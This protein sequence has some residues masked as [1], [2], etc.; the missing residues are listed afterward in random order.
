[1]AHPGRKPKRGKAVKTACNI[2]FSVYP[3]LKAGAR[4]KESGFVVPN[5]VRKLKNFLAASA[6]VLLLVPG[7][8][9]ARKFYPDDPLAKAPPPRPVASA[10]SR[11][12]SEY[13]DFF[14][15]TFAQPGERH[16]PARRI[17]AQ[18]VNTLGEVPDSGWYTNRHYRNS[19]S[20]AEL[21]RGAG[22][23]NAPSS[24]GPW[25]VVAAKAEG[26]TPGFTVV[27]P[28]GRRYVLKFDP[29]TN[30]EMATAADV[31]SS[32]F[33]HALGYFVPDNYIVEFAREQL[34]LGEAVQLRDALGRARPMTERDLAEVLLNVPRSRNGQYRAVASFYLSGRPLGPFRYYGTRR[35]DP[36]DV[37]PHEHRRDLRGLSI[38]CA[39]LGH[40]DS[41]SIN[42]LDI[43]V[44]ES[45][46]S[47]LQHFL[48]DFGSTLGSASNGP[49]S[50]RSGHEYLFS[51][52]P[53]MVQFFTFGLL[54]PSWARAKYPDLPSVGRFEG[55]RF[56]A[57][58]WMPEYRNA[59]F[60]NRLPDDEFWAAKQVMAFSDDEIRAIVRTGRYSDPAA[61]RWIVESLIRRRDKIGRA[62]FPKVLPLDR[63]AVETGRLVFQD[64]GARYNLAAP[65]DYRIQWFRFD[66]EAET[67]TPLDGETTF[68]LPQQIETAAA[69]QYFAADIHAGDPKQMV[70]VYLRKQPGHVEVVGIERSW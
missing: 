59:A 53:A 17:P 68:S 11:K 46:L 31:I 50:P 36:N 13:Y 19:L 44:E 66:N 1:L 28:R 14:F 48:I 55:E 26:I 2:N 32:K 22:G 65:R 37:V 24:D 52:K 58:R 43:L 69:G 23:E 30:P 62:F 34:V 63:F 5:E 57:E 29:L 41:R 12:L 21:A 47:Y 4:E 8:L 6:L 70:T 7:P 51:W 45:G 35:D 20:P 9:H 42:T 54:V 25:T 61:E 64:L 16:R 40:D 3:G 33:F 56:D 27:D 18:E 67:K 49:N 60:S 38:F 15:N 10:L 39:W